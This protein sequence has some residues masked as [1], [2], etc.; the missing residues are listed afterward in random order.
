MGIRAGI[1]LG[2]TFS[3]VAMIDEATGK[4]VVIKNSY[5]K[6]ITP[7]VLC[8]KSDG[9]ILYG[10]DAKD[11][12]L[13]GEDN[14]V[15]FFKR[16]MGKDS[17]S[18][19]IYGKNYTATDFSAIFL[20]K[21]KAEAEQQI[22]QKIDAAVIT[23]PAYFAEK[24]RQATIEAGKRAGLTV[25][26]IINEPT[27]AAL[28]YGLTGNA[29]EQTVLIYDLG[30][31][32][33]DVTVARINKE[34]INILGSDGNHELGGKDWDDSIARHLAAEFKE[35]YGADITEDASMIASLLVTAENVKKQLTLRDSINVPINY[36]NIKGNIEITGELFEGISEFLLGT[37][38]DITE[39]LL[40]D[41]KFSWKNIDGVI[42][43]GGSTRMRMIG[44]YIK[45]M[46][47]KEPLSG[48]NVDEAVALGA[49]IKANIGG[50]GQ[51]T[52]TL[53]GTSAGN[54]GPVVAIKGAKKVR[55]VSAHTLGMIAESVD[56]E[57][58]INESIIRKN[59]P[60]PASKTKIFNFNTRSSELE[61]YVL[62]GDES[63]P[64]DNNI[65]YKYT[66]SNIERTDPAVSEIE[67]SYHYTVNGVIEVSAVQK[68][69]GRSLPVR[70]EPIPQDMIWTD[71]C[72]RDQAPVQEPPSVEVL[73][74]VDVSG[75]MNGPP[76]KEAQKAMKKFIDEMDREYTKIGII[77]FADQEN[78]IVKP[79][80]DFN[81]AKRAVDGIWNVSVGRGNDTEPF[82]L[83]RSILK[84]GLLKKESQIRYI[85]V[86]TDGM[87]SYQDRAV[88]AAK[89][90]HRD[91]IEVMAL[92]FGG[93]DYNFLKKIASVDAFAELTNLSDLGGS[94][95]KIAQA[96]NT[97]STGLSAS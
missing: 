4:P 83:A 93:A 78:C 34:E 47:G 25:L 62:Q 53:S 7:S 22:H 32:T 82:T 68:A 88:K 8:F 85:V 48:V 56:R 73:L 43:V 94:F 12:Q 33:F 17:F 29:E 55:D 36:K 89:N 65:L 3:V 11:M 28:A 77:P 90:C 10:E 58:Y 27:A 1:D 95:S 63:R 40:S 50:K 18:I 91:G 45:E 16:S 14:T 20:E 30:G 64:L 39:R 15:S 75:S 71:G 21:L 35:K 60:I 51:S 49:A 69:T 44:K 54:T 23:V 13:A 41:I 24:E 61:V 92:G 97:G 38:R 84:G 37:T 80:K 67:V 19:S 72:P 87:W 57:R 26:E 52:L 96:I 76:I 31:G 5:D 79:T 74:C 86:L 70:A 6:A 9:T 2:T 42:L 46:S 59:T 66:V 81:E